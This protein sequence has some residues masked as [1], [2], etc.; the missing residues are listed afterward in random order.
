MRQRGRSL[1][2]VLSIAIVIC[3][4][5]ASCGVPDAAISRSLG[6]PGPAQAIE[7]AAFSP[8]G[9]LL[10]TANPDATI[11][12]WDMASGQRRFTLAGHGGR[13]TALAFSPDGKSLASGATDK[14]VELWDVTAGKEMRALNGHTTEVDAVAFSPDGKTLASGGKDGAVRQWD[15]SS[16]AAKQSLSASVNGGVTSLAYSPNGQSL[17]SGGGGASV[18]LWN[19]GSGQLTKSFTGHKDAVGTV[20]FSPDGQSLATG[21][22]DRE[23]KLWSVQ[24][25]KEQ[26]SLTGHTD[27]VGAVAFS[28]DGKSLASGSLDKTARLWDATSGQTR[29]TLTGHTAAVPAVAFSPDGKS[30]STGSRDNSAKQWDATSGKLT[31]TINVSPEAAASPIDGLWDSNYGPVTLY[32]KSASGG[33]R[34][35]TGFWIQDSLGSCATEVGCRGEIKSGTFDPATG[36]LDIAYIQPWNNVDG[37][38]TFRLTGADL[39]GSF[40]QSN[41][42]GDWTLT[43]PKA[44]SSVTPTV[45]TATNLVA[46]GDFECPPIASSYQTFSAGQAFCGW[47]VKEQSVDIVGSFL[48][49][50]EGKQAV[51][52]AGSPGM[53]V[54]EQYLLTQPGQTYRIRFAFAGNPVGGPTKKEVVVEWEDRQLGTE[55]FDITG[56]SISSMGWVYKEFTA[57]A[58]G[59]ATRLAF[60]SLTDGSYGPVIDDVSVVPAGAAPSVTPT[61]RAQA[62]VVAQAT[63]APPT[64]THPATSTATS[65]P[66]T[67]TLLPSLTVTTTVPPPTPTATATATRTPLP[68]SPTVTPTVAAASRSDADWVKVLTNDPNLRVKNTKSVFTSSNLEIF[69]GTSTTSLG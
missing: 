24:D 63:S 12:I 37:T 41:G 46:D 40:V 32:T 51:D 60:R 15:V 45:T 2:R 10:A 38:A 34:S 61:P 16:G 58:S 48:T 30:L 39:V 23:V 64:A 18:Q 3:I 56:H 21:S 7:L 49:A 65:L 67:S 69:Y 13:I 22:K 6:T 50:A 52:L 5:L 1:L 11:A 42:S 62:P 4:G 36:R 53:G 44:G 27:A 17:A 43:R 31:K 55:S 14:R 66:P 19:A 59:S 54:I 68:P 35:V 9:A 29:Q 33:K 57:T 20:A 26:R 25:G 47:A 28:P 8:G